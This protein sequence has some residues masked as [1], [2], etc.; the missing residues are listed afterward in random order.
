MRRHSRLYMVS[1]I[2]LSIAY[3][4]MPIPDSLQIGSGA[5][6]AFLSLNV[7]L[8]PVLRGITWKQV[9]EDLGLHLDGN[10]LV[11]ILSGFGCY[12][13]AVPILLVGALIT[14]VLMYAQKQLHLG[15]PAPPSHP[16]VLEA[17]GSSPWI[18]FQI[19]LAACVAAPI[20]EEIMFRGVLYRHLREASH[21]WGRGLSIFF[22]V[23]LSS[24]V[25]AAIHPQGWL[26]VPPLMAM[27]TAF[28]LAREWRRSL[29]P[30][31]IA[32]GINNGV[33]TLMLLLTAA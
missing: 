8:W 23:L 25:F 24:F 7:L 14:L 12:L 4:F 18:W 15:E 26:G 3:R 20:V 32:H 6:V 30:P 16:I 33:I 22:S 9:R 29:L 5:M 19:F 27:A 13:C 21:G 28:C 10:P 31:I 11:Q 17:L 1:F 2:G